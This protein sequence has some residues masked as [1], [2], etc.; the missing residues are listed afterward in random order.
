MTNL[1]TGRSV[2]VR[3]NDRGPYN[4]RFIIDLSP[5][6]AEEIGVRHGHD[7]ELAQAL[8][9]DRGLRP[10]QAGHQPAISVLK[11]LN[12]DRKLI[13]VARHVTGSVYHPDLVLA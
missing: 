4:H 5:R 2:I 6:A 12:S 1:D 11:V 9:A 3:I 13:A 10:D 8:R 7:F